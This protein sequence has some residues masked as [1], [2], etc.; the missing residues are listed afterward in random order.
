MTSP[1]ASASRPDAPDLAALSEWAPELARTFVSLASDIALVIDGGG[2]IRNVEQGPLEPIAPAAHEWIGRPW[3]DTVSGDTRSKVENLLRDVAHNGIARRREVNHPLKPGV[4]LPVAYTAIRL[5]VDGPVLAVGRDLRA[6]AAIQQRFLESQQNMERDYWKARQQES[7]YQLLFQVATDAVLVVDAETL[8]I[9]EANQAAAQML[10]SGAETL[11]G[12]HATVGFEHRSRSAVNGLLVAARES[13]EGGEIRARLLGRTDG[14]SVSATPFRADDGMRLL[15]RVR[16]AEAVPSSDMQDTLARLVDDTEDGVVV[17]DSS[18]RILLAN[19]AFLALVG[20][21][22]EADA[23]GRMLT[24]WVGLP[25]QPIGRLIA[26]ARRAGILR[27]VMSSVRPNGAAPAPIEFSAALLTE[28]EQ[29]CI[30]FTIRRTGPAE[31]PA[32]GGAAAE[33]GS[34]IE[35]LAARIGSESLPSLL[36]EAHALVERYFA[37]RS[38][39]LG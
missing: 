19:R 24:D 34:G 1:P 6:V 15:V 21:G 36:D 11:A 27:R 23:K 31:A 4:N 30:G 16:A 14:A 39:R 17:T 25:E 35:R 2:V 13:G 9:V 20:V 26:Q 28:G 3:I 7:R 12:R 38:A 37:E 18:G 10:G 5:G 32:S 29:E 33:L 22:S 8:A